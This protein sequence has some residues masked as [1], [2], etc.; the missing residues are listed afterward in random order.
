MPQSILNKLTWENGVL[1]QA[2]LLKIV[3][4]FL[5]FGFSQMATFQKYQKSLT[6]LY[7]VVFI[8][9][10]LYYSPKQKNILINHY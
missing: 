5:R 10:D 6:C 2:N 7:I 9:K 4:N 3:T 8:F 1:A